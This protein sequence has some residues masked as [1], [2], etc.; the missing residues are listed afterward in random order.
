MF[1]PDQS[2]L[3]HIGGD[4][5]DPM[6]SGKLGMQST[7]DLEKTALGHPEVK[8]VAR[9]GTAYVITA[10][11]YKH[12]GAPLEVL[13][14]CPL[15]SQKGAMHTL[16]IREDR[17]KIEYD[18]ARN[19]LSIAPFKCTWDGQFGACSWAVEIDENVARDV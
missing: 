16:K 3:V 14:F 4:V 2:K 11:V 10:D 19:L 5:P 8:Y 15:C 7:L 6:G 12:E 17:K 9:D 1:T 18:E 13:L